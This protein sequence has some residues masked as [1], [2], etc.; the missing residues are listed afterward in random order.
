MLIQLESVI[1]NYEIE[2]QTVPVLAGV[3]LEIAAGE[4]V[5]IMGPSGSGKSTLMNILGC[6][7]TLSS[8]SYRLDGIDVSKLSPDRLSE[9]RRAKIGFI[10]QTFNLITK[11]T[12]QENVELPM[13]YNRIRERNHKAQRM[14]ENVGLGHRIKHFPGQMSGGER[15]RVAIARALINDP[16]IIMADEPTGNLDSKSGEQ[17]LNIIR[18][19][20]RNNKTIIMV[21]HDRHVAEQAQRIIHLK[22][23]LIDHIEVL[24]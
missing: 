18:G 23:G 16:M 1:K 6:L 12:A 7:D 8:G 5:A 9:I 14:L 2:E 17:V 11:L 20:H 24:S 13:I 3:N 22:D 15:Q 21:T 19:L 4:Y 10:F